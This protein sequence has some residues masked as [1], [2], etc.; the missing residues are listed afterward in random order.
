MITCTNPGLIPSLNCSR[1]VAVDN[2]TCGHEAPCLS[3]AVQLAG[4]GG[5]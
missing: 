4:A 5:V 2:A 1:H 3:N